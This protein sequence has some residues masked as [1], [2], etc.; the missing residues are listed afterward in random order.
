MKDVSLIIAAFLAMP[1]SASADASA[2][3][4]LLNCQM[5]N[6]S[7][8]NMTTAYANPP[9]DV[10]NQF[11]KDGLE[12]G[13][14]GLFVFPPTT[15]E[16]NLST[17]TIVSPEESHKVLDITSASASKI[18]AHSS[19]GASFLLNRINLSMKY[20]VHI[21]TAKAAA[22]KKQHGGIIPEILSYSYSCVRVK[23]I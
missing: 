1:I 12:Q 14:I 9:K 19:F 3:P 13:I 15:W 7:G 23:G 5:V 16:V 11:L 10:R 20:F 8:F 17:N 6:G 18:E 22:W 2:D 21:G 4:I